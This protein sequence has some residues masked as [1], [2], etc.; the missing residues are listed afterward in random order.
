MIL[1][2]TVLLLLGIVLVSPCLA[3]PPVVLK[4]GD[5]APDF[6]LQGSDG[7]EYTLAQFL[8]KKAVALCWFPRAGSQGAK[9]QCAA[10]EAVMGG[11]P[12]DRL[13]VFGCSTQPLAATTAFAEQGRYSF[14]VLSDADGA[15]ARAFG[16]LR[17]DGTSERW[18]FLIDDKGIVLAINKSI[19]PQTQG[20]E[21]VK[22][23]TDVGFTVPATAPQLKPGTS[24]SVQFPDM[25]PTFYDIAEGRDDKAQMTVFIPKNYDPG[26]KW[27]LLLWLSGGDG[28]IGGNPGVARGVCADQDFVCVSVPLFR[29]PDYKPNP[30]GNGYIITEPDGRAMWPYLKTMLAKLDEMVP[31]LDPAHQVLGGSSNG[32]HMIAALI[33]GSDGEVTKRFTAFVCVEGAGKLRRYDLLEGKPFLM[34]SSN[35]GSLPRATEIAD[36]ASTA[37]AQAALIFEDIGKHGFPQSAYPKV[38]EWLRGPALQ[39]VPA[40]ANGGVE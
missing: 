1:R 37:G 27:P 3:Q 4:P 8:G 17:P 36:A 13:Q 7:K 18:T 34:V 10:L 19:T 22:M 30:P 16:A 20:A 40:D 25:P 21:L 38:R 31:N 11:L 28:G 33:D 29:A 24:F 35:A 2:L 39:P 26:R 6:K 15:A 32:A 12:T 9:N 14:P 5:K 23:L